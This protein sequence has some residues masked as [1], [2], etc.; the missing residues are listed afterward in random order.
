MGRRGD[1]C[2]AHRPPRRDAR[3][4]RASP[5]RPVAD[6]LR[7]WGPMPFEIDRNLYTR[8][9]GPTVGDRVRLGDTNLL[10]EVERDETAYGD[11][12]LWGFGKTL[13]DSM[14]MTSVEGR[15]SALDLIVGNALVMDP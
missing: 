5:L 13:R 2:V 1:A 12:P 6:Y 8:L 14:Q 4:T 11:E 10:A 7:G 9:Y 15:D 3:T